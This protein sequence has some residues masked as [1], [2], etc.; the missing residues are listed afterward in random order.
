LRCG[1]ISAQNFLLSQLRLER[2]A[3]KEIKAKKLI[4]GGHVTSLALMR[5]PLIFG[6]FILKMAC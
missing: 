3:K 1:F 5:Q 6:K 4:H 2:L